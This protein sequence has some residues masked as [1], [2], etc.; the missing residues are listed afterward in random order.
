MFEV[1]PE[2]GHNFLAGMILTAYGDTGGEAGSTEKVL[3]AFEWVVL[4]VPVLSGRQGQVQM[5]GAIR[6]VRI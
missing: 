6:V 5:A 3:F 4:E 1:K 2:R